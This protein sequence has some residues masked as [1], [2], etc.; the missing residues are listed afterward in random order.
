MNPPAKVITFRHQNLPRALRKRQSLRML[1][2]APQGFHIIFHHAV[3]G[4]EQ[5]HFLALCLG[6]EQSIKWVGVVEGQISNGYRV[7]VSY[8][9]G[10]N[11]GGEQHP[12]DVPSRWLRKRQFLD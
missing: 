1:F 10:L 8:W 6:H 7:Y 11:S 2:T 9:Q 5:D 3:V 4:R 12:R